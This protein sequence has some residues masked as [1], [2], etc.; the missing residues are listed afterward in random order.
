[1]NIIV[2]GRVE[3]K[4]QDHFE[5]ERVLQIGKGSQVCQFSALCAVNWRQH[6]FESKQLPI[7]RGKL[8]G[9]VPMVSL[10]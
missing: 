1:M 10:A 5:G 4:K 2:N 6:D 8:K 9:S 7:H 3:G